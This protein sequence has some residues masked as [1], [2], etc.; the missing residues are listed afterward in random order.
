MENNSDKVAKQI[1]EKLQ[2]SFALFADLPG[3]EL[4]EYE[5]IVN[6]D[7]P[8]RAQLKVNSLKDSVISVL[9]SKMY[10]KHVPKISQ[11]DVDALTVDLQM[12]TEDLAERGYRLDEVVVNERNRVTY[13]ITGLDNS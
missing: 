5:K 12:L 3:T 11:E 2:V 1:H 13:H 7:T 4:S 9:G 6:S 8:E 10:D